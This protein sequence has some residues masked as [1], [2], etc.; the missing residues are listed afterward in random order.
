[1]SR[2]PTKRRNDR[3]EV[4]GSEESKDPELAKL[5]RQEEEK[6]RLREEEKKEE[7]RRASEKEERDRLRQEQLLAA[8]RRPET[9]AAAQQA[10]SGPAFPPPPAN[11]AASMLAEI[12]AARE[13]YKNG[14]ITRE[15]CTA[16]CAAAREL[17]RGE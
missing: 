8:L 15:D 12:K 14:E 5:E 1:M 6:E 4:V 13:A 11:V 16:I 10:L 3:V 17:A 2:V 9:T 7:G